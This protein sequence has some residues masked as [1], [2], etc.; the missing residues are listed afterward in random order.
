M[1]PAECEVRLWAG[2]SDG[3]RCDLCQRAIPVS[4]LEYEVEART[5]QGTT[6]LHFHLACYRCWKIE[7]R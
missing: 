6:L 2:R 7:L 4:E 5:G 1:I 3:V